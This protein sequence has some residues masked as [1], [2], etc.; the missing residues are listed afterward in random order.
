MK[1]SYGQ[2]VKQEGIAS[3]TLLFFDDWLLSAREGLDRK[4]GQC[5]LL[6]EVKLGTL[7][8]SLIPFMV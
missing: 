4:Q 1:T 3:K 8:L 7:I 5:N 6:K 2:E